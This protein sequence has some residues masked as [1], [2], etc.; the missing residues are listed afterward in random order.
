[1]KVRIMLSIALIVYASF[2]F[3]QVDK[4]LKTWNPIS[5]AQPVV[6]GQAWPLEVEDFYDRLPPKAQQKVRKEVWDLSKNSAGLQMRFKSN[7]NNIEIRYLVS[8][9]LQMPH[10]PAT[11][12]SG[13]D[14]YAKNKDN[15]WIWAAGKYS[16][17]DTI[18]YKFNDLQSSES[19]SRE[20]TLYL[21]LYNTVR[22][23]E[24]TVDDSAEFTP[25]VAR[26]EKPIVV[27]GTSIAQGGC[28]SR[29]GLAWT[30]ILGRKLDEP[31][32]NLGFSGNGRLENELI[33]LMTEID[34]KIYVLD[35]L[36]NLTS[37]LISSAELKNR[38]EESVRTLQREKPETPILLTE[39]DGYT[40]EEINSIK[41]EDYQKVNRVLKEAFNSMREQG[42]KNIY[43]LS[44]EE[45][46]QD[47]DSMVDGVH[48]ND[49]GMM[50]YAEA[51][52]NSIR[53]ILNPK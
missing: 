3:A 2:S 8:G 7:A 37:P 15:Q 17:G 45:I 23:L 11:G 29:P 48:P 46:N 28:A 10:M 49:I 31:I 52:E 20:Y 41:R 5:E 21:P 53:T 34:A 50:R 27:Y 26:N 42:I 22:W 32:V 6:E 19:T 51:Y 44:K 33:E 13:L 25:L 14:L 16:F 38:I 9:R 43:L 35:C 12:V 18:V 47:I 39:H 30:N 1:M 4:K 24:V 36:P 40:D